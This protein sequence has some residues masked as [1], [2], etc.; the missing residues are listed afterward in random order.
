[1]CEEFLFFPVVLHP[2]VFSTQITIQTNL[3][4]QIFVDQHMEIKKKKVIYNY[5][6][7]EIIIF[8]LYFL[9]THFGL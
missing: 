6:I 4:H 8:D 3:F 1:M 5:E 7:S 9:S 2:V